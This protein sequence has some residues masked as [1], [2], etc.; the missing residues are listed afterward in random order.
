MS[1]KSLVEVGS[2]LTRVVSMDFDNLNYDIGQ[3]LIS[4]WIEAGKKFHVY[5]LGAVAD[6]VKYFHQELLAHERIF[7]RRERIPILDTSIVEVLC[8]LD[9][10]TG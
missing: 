3:L 2:L 4:G 1:A 10:L 7:E 9:E 5:Q 6:S 8:V